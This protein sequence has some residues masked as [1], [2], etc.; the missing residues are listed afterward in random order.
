MGSEMSKVVSGLYIGDFSNA[1]NVEKLKC[2]NITHVL[3]VCQSNVS[4]VVQSAL[5]SLFL[6]LFLLMLLSVII[7]N[8]S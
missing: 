5:V 4:S 6:N 8:Q 7:C 2:N 1:K 3:S